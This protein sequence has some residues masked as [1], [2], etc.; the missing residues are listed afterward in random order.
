MEKIS[1][2]EVLSFLVP[3]Y[4]LL[5]FADY[6]LLLVLE[7]QPFLQQQGL[8][9]NIF[10]LLVAMFLGVIFHMFTFILIRNKRIKWIIHRSVDEHVNKDKDLQ[11]IRA[12]I[13]EYSERNGFK[14]SDYFDQAYY[15]LEVNGKINV[16][17]NFQSI[18]FWLRN[19]FCIFLLLIACQIIILILSFCIDFAF[20]TGI[21]LLFL[22][23]SI[24]FTLIIIP[25][26]Q[27]Y[28]G[29]MIDRILWSYYDIIKLKKNE[30][31]YK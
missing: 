14:V 5:F 13:K 20:N 21:A 27:F 7:K 22:I 17:K 10:Y 30:H 1:L 9:K 31:E 25:P 24:V 28:R 23:S 8:G 11:R 15:H 29:K 12:F 4:F 19:T 2:Y 3:G 16:A 26:I 6:Y 18:Y